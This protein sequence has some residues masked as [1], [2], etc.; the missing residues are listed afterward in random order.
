MSSE[1]EAALADQ[2][3]RNNADRG[4]VIRQYVDSWHFWH[5]AF[6]RAWR[7]KHSCAE[8]ANGRGGAARHASSSAVHGERIIGILPLMRIAA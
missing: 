7:T 4:A 6:F 8:E 1:R 5:A 2:A 3:T